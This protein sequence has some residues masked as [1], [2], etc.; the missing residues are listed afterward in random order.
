[1][2]KTTPPRVGI[3]QCLLGDNVRYDGGH[4]LDSVLIETLGRYVEWVPV[5]PEVEVGLGTPREPMRL[6]G[7][8]HAPRLITINT[9]MDYTEAMNCFARQRVRELEALNLSGFVFKSASPSCGITGVSL[10]NGQGM[11]THDGVGLFA[12][13]FMAH[14]PEMPVEEESRLHDPQ[15]LKNFLDHVLAYRRKV[16]SES[17]S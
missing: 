7:D 6:V 16:G 8:R 10:F 2:T 14:F 17:L 3:S 12:R 1:M 5:C 4:K 9:G 11:E 13:A 15:A